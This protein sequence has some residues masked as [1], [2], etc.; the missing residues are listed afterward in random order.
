MATL[1]IKKTMSFLFQ[2]CNTSAAEMARR[3]NEA[4]GE[5]TSQQSLS[6]K[7]NKGVMKAEEWDKLLQILGYR[8]EVVPLEKNPSRLHEQGMF[9]AD[10]IIT[11]DKRNE[12]SA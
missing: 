12:V 5:H 9:I 4:Y 3:Y 1:D 6:R 11:S 2:H 10:S 7:I 8:V